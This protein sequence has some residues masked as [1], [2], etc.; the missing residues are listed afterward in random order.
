MKDFVRSKNREAEMI[1]AYY[2]TCPKCARVFGKNHVV[3]FAKI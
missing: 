3:L 1:F 2:A